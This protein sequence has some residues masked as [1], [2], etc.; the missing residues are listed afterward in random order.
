MTEVVKVSPQQ[1][2]RAELEKLKPELERALPQH[3]TVDKWMRIATSAV[4]MAPK[5]LSD[6]IDRRSLYAA[7]MLSAQDGLLPDNKEAAL[8]PFKGV[9]KYMPMI[10]GILKK[11]RNSGELKTI[12]PQVVHEKDKFDYF[13]DENGEHLTH[14]P[15]LDGDPGKVTFAYAIALMKDGGKYVE[16]MT[17]GQIEQVRKCSRGGDTPWVGWYDE[18]AK[19]TVIRRLSK[20][21]PMSTDLE[22]VI[23][24]DDDLY[25]PKLASEEQPETTTPKRLAEKL[26]TSPVEAPAVTAPAPV[27]APAPAKPEEVPI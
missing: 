17:F 10:G 15:S 23:R 6:E 5:L 7:L 16:V 8:V 9:V 3:I 1:A 27:A 2:F 26:G 19:K 20:R 12:I 25:D 24:R 18:M 4:F 22:D 13:V 14:R 21:L 11:A